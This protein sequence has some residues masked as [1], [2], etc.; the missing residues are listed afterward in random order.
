MVSGSM[1]VD[2]D[3][4]FLRLGNVNINKGEKNSLALI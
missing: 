1:I 3:Q 2:V 4:L